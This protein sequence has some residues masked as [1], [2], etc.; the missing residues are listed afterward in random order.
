MKPKLR[1]AFELR[2]AAL[3]LLLA[4]GLAGVSMAYANPLTNGDVSKLLSSG[5]SPEQITA[6]L[7]KEGY[8]GP[9]DKETLSNLR[10]KGA[11]PELILALS[12][13]AR[14]GA[15]APAAATPKIVY[16]NSLGMKFV[17]VPGTQVLFCIHLTRGSDFNAY[18]AAS[19][20]GVSHFWRSVADDHPAINVSWDDA[21]SFCRWLSDKEQRTYRL[22]TDHDWSCAVGIGSQEDP[23]ASPW[24]K[25][26]RIANVYPWGT[27][28]PPPPGAG[29]L[30]DDT[31]KQIAGYGI[32][33]YHDGF[34][35]TSPVV[36]FQPN[37]FGLHDMAGNVWQWCDD[38]R[39][40]DERY[41]I[42][43]GSSYRIAS[44]NDLLASHRGW[45]PPAVRIAEVGFRVVVTP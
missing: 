36:R 35:T 38:W 19:L 14:Q 6:V 26:N 42:V 10:T 11:P 12:T 18:A 21:M 3:K 43:R 27:Q 20:P 29:N 13:Y 37:Q 28:W 5:Q 22:P 34:A 33:G 23:H 31:Y 9:L 24:S 32:D 7:Q 45:I 4:L 17:S 2:T 30:A 40:Q 16:T 41:R 25:D 39:D 44:P 8:A 1:A 15:P